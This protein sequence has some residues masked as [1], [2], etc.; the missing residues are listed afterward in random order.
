MTNETTVPGPRAP[1][2]FDKWLASKTNGMIFEFKEMEQAKAFAAV[3]KA[4]FNLDSRVFDDAEAAAKAHMFPWEQYPPV[5]HI[6]RPWWRIPVD[7][8]KEAF[9]KALD[10][11]SKLETKIEKM[12][13]KWGGVF[14]GT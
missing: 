1:T 6:D 10:E 4:T 7:T 8:P 12:A 2:D 5:V 14:V 11:T 9:A 3:V 13:K